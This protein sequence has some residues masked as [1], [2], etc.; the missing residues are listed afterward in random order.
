MRTTKRDEFYEVTYS[1]SHSYYES[2]YVTDSGDWMRGEERAGYHDDFFGSIFKD[3][4]RRASSMR[5]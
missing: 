2:G 4:N 3:L 5:V 1:E